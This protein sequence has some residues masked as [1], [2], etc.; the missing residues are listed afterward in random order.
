M[1]ESTAKVKSV[2]EELRDF[3][4]K[5]PDPDG[6]TLL[7][8]THLKDAAEV[9][10]LLWHRWLPQS[11]KNFV[12]HELFGERIA[13]AFCKYGAAVH[14]A[15]KADPTYFSIF[16]AIR[17]HMEQLGYPV[18]LYRGDERPRHETT[19]AVELRSWLKEKT[20]ASGDI[21]NRLIFPVLAHHGVAHS[22][23]LEYAADQLGAGAPESERYL[24]YKNARHAIFDWATELVGLTADDWKKLTS[25]K[26]HPAVAVV[27]SG[28]VIVADWIASNRNLFPFTCQQSTVRAIEGYQR[29]ALPGPWKVSSR[30]IAGDGFATAFG[31]PEGTKARPVQRDAMTVAAACA[32]APLMII[33]APTGEGKT[34][35]ALAA[36]EILAGK[37]GCG[38]IYMALPTCASSDGLFPRV[39]DFLSGS[40]DDG[41]AASIRLMHGRAQFND[42]YT[43]LMDSDVTHVDD[44]D[45]TCHCG[46]SIAPHQWFSGRKQ[47]LLS[48]FVVGTIDQVLMAGLSTR[49]LMLRHLGLAGKVV[50]LDEVH[51][52]DVVMKEYLKLVLGWLS[53]MHVPVIALSATLQPDFKK[54]LL[55]AYWRGRKTATSM[56][57]LS[58]KIDSAV[59]EK[60]TDVAEYDAYPLITVQVGEDF[61]VHAPTPSARS[62]SVRFTFEEGDCTDLSQIASRIRDIA[63]DGGCLLV[64]MN[65]VGRAQ[66][67]FLTL[68]EEAVFDRDELVLLHSRFVANERVRIEKK[69]MNALGPE[70][71][72]TQRPNRMVVIATQVV[73]Q[74]LDIDADAMITDI[75][76][77]DL[78]IQRIGRLH[79][80]P[81]PI[82]TRPEKLRE[83]VVVISGMERGETTPKFERG[84]ELIYSR[85]QLLR[86]VAA[87]DQ[88][89][90]DKGE[91][92]IVSPDDVHGLVAA[93]SDMDRPGPAEWEPEWSSSALDLEKK[94]AKLRERT[95]GF[96]IAEVARGTEL[97]GW[98]S[99]W[100]SRSEA[101]TISGVRNAENS[102]TVIVVQSVDGQ[103]QTLPG[104]VEAESISIPTELPLDDE[105]AKNIARCCVSFPGWFSCL[106]EET[107]M[108]IKHL[109]DHNRFP[110]WQKSG[111]LSG[112]VPLVLDASCRAV[113]GEWVFS[114]DPAIGLAVE[115]LRK[116]DRSTG[117][118]ANG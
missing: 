90:A 85:G 63:S 28:L 52:S 32:E 69:V 10:D 109:S 7:L 15:G 110:S 118:T 51:A 106:R 49:H 59:T 17:S 5:T 73:E 60:I 19:G 80:H 39:L 50:I 21:I 44:D 113:I 6:N 20:D 40:I 56:R 54:E 25:R 76:P 115:K 84:S 86:S 99:K 100:D 102:V 77:V 24:R 114:Y 41:T 53:A 18:P 95:K 14:D 23:T 27:V 47:G 101:G 38:G 35:A 13:L 104:T 96:R 8:V 34:E 3:W 43:A 26:L 105:L 78:L 81:R 97:L 93:A 108:V 89:A 94:E 33:E 98:N 83:P 112:E 92:V 70:K 31:L 68:R 75:A 65:T 9:M 74:S 1:S 72:G 66:K 46:G 42:R 45:E 22:S 67:L 37:F 4:A 55:T 87:L 57:A 11:V 64:V 58:R 103:L 107:N 117:V 12:S 62:R 79:R 116:S 48:E 61:K 29:L 111:W 91:P 2:P 71:A 36:A 16:S 30:T 82:E 88:L